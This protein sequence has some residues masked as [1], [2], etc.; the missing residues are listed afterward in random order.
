M[1][2]P[3]LLSAHETAEYLTV[4]LDY[5]RRVIRYEVPVIQR[6]PRGPLRFWR[7]DLDRWLA[8]HTHQP[9]R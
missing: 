6:N 4:S 3:D 1:N 8:E 7:R 2:N 5:V 9:V